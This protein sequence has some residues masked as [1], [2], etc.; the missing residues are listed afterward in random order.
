MGIGVALGRIGKW[1]LSN[2]KFPENFVNDNVRDRSKVQNERGAEILKTVGWPEWTGL[3]ESLK[4]LIEGA[5]T[6]EVYLR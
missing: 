3:E 5:K 4:N 6:C 1:I 2:N